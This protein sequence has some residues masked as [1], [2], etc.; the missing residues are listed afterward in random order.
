MN[1]SLLTELDYCL[2]FW[3]NDM[4]LLTELSYCLVFW[5]MDMSLLTE[6]RYCLGLSSYDYIAPN[7]AELLFGFFGLW[8]YRS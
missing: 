4:S 2:V 1:M 7:G 3:V 5:V 8:I 6:L